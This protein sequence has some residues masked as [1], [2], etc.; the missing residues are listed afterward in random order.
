MPDSCYRDAAMT[1]HANT[2]LQCNSPM[3]NSAVKMHRHSFTCENASTL[4]DM[5][6]GI[7]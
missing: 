4:D 5:E 1:F 7:R 2:D 6:P 3:A